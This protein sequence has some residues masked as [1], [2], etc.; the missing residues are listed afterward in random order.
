MQSPQALC[1]GIPAPPV[2]A[3]SGAAPS[4]PMGMVAMTV[5]SLEQMVLMS[6]H[7]DMARGMQM[8][9]PGP[10]QMADGMPIITRKP[11]L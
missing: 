9:Y 4:Q 3:M 8:P 10:S 1:S 2:G 7:S 6:G 11:T 5:P